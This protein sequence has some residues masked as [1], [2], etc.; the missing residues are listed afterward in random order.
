MCAA[1]VS[2]DGTEFLDLHLQRWDWV[3]SFPSS[4]MGL[5]FWISIFEDGTGFLDLHLQRWDWVSSSLPSKMGLG[6]KFSISA[7]GT[8]FSIYLFTSLH[9][10][11]HIH[12]AK[13]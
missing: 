11:M 6:F 13:V 10:H 4:K 7:E 12:T 2:A 5:G 1:L 8:Q 9:M 3:S